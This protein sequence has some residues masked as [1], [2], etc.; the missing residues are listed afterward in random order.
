[1]FIYLEE[2]LVLFAVNKLI[3]IY[4]K[5]DLTTVSVVLEGNDGFDLLHDTPE[6]AKERLDYLAFLSIRN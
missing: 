4:I 6:E 1:M 3:K 2:E 5:N